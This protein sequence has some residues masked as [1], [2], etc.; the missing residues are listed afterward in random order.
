MAH[1]YD[2]KAKTGTARAA[3]RYSTVPNKTP[4]SPVLAEAREN[5]RGQVPDER[6]AGAPARQ[7]SNSGKVR[8]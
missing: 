8:K 2:S 7:I 5:P 1:P 3:A 4:A 6:Y